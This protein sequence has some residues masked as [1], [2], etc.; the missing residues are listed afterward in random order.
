MMSEMP[1]ELLELVSDADVEDVF[2]GTNFGAVSP[3][4][5]IADTLLK[6]AG[7]YCSGYTALQCCTELGLI[8]R[9]KNGFDAGKVH[10]L[11]KKG[12]KYLFYAFHRADAVPD[13]EALKKVR[14]AI[15]LAIMTH[16]YD[17]GN[18]EDIIK[19]REALALLPKAGA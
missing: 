16:Y 5:V 4:K 8:V 18:C 11:T 14:E 3:R 15:E 17:R 6:M 19:L 7:G 1:K 2:H 13:A 10:R 9:S 12:R